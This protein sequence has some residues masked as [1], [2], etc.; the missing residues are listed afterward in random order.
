MKLDVKLDVILQDE[1]RLNE[2]K[3]GS[4]WSSPSSGFCLHPLD[5]NRVSQDQ[6][7]YFSSPEMFTL[8]ESSLFL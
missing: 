3:K 8:T 7:V 2:E 6:L 1:T 4:E 5:V